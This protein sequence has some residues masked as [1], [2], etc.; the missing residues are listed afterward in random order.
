MAIAGGLLT[1]MVAGGLLVGALVA[2]LPGP[3]Q[4]SVAPT[5]SPTAAPASTAVPTPTAS[6]SGTPVAPEAPASPAPSAGSSEPSASSVA[7]ALPVHFRIDTDGIVRDGALGGRGPDV[8]AMGL[9]LILPGV[10]VTP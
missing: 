8:M 3:E 4:R 2:F 10:T 7:E 6:A 5:A 1:G 9:A